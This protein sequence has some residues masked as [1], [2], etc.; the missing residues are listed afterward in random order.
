MSK[1]L[2]LSVIVLSV[3]TFADDMEHIRQA[4]RYGADSQIEVTVVHE[5]GE[6][7]ESFTRQNEHG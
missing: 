3:A 6:C 1:F 7:L 2:A 5:D 4:Q